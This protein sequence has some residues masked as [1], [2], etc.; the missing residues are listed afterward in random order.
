M[1]TGSSPTSNSMLAPDIIAAQSL[2]VEPE[3]FQA[4]LIKNLTKALLQDSPAPCLLR[5]PTGAGK[6]FVISRVLEAVSTKSPTIWLWFVP[7]VNLIQQTED[8]I[9]ANATALTPVPLV[10]G[11]NQEPASGLVALSTAAAVA[12]ATSRNAGYTDGVD[13]DVRSLEQ[14]VSLA[15]ARGFKIGLVVDEAH[16]GLATQTEFGK[17]ARWLRA[18][19]IVMASA[20]PKDQRLNDFLASAGLAG[21]VSFTASRDDVVN[22]RL[23]KRYIEAVV[24]DL[25][26]SMQTVTDL[27]QTVLRQAWRRNQR[28]LKQ[29]EA[30][31]M[32]FRPLLLVQVGNGATAVADARQSLMSLCNVNPAAIGEH[33]SDDPDPVLMASIANDQTKDVLIFKQSAGTGFDAPRAFVLA[34]TK[35][36]NDPDFALQFIGRVMRVHRQIRASYPR[37]SRVPVEL[38]TAYVYLANAQAQQGFEQ[39]VM[40]TAA[41]RSEL[42]GQTE[43]LVTR[44]TVAGGLHISNRATDEP[45]LWFDMPLPLPG[46]RP[47]PTAGATYTIGSSAGLFDGLDPQSD[48]ESTDDDPSEG[49]SLDVVQPP[50]ARTRRHRALPKD[51]GE[52]VE[53]LMD[54]GIRPYALRRSLREVPA[55]LM[56]EDRPVM[57][58]MAAASRSAAT[59]LEIAP[60]VLKTAVAV[61]LGRSLEQEVHTELTQGSV[62][63]TDVA[64]LVDRA[65]LAREARLVLAGLPQAE[66]ADAAIII[67][68]L[69]ARVLGAIEAEFAHLPE[70]ERP[71]TAEL[72]KRARD[73]AFWIIRKAAD[74][75][76]EMMH[77]EIAL[78]ARPVHSG[79]LP[80]YMVFPSSLALESSSKNLYGVLPPSRQTMD[81]LA[82]AVCIDTRSLMQTRSFSMDGEQ[83]LVS[84]YD[85]S[86]AL[87]DEERTF[88]RSLDRAPFV[89][90]WHRNPDRKPYSARL[91]RGEH[92]NY[93]YPDFIVCLEHFPGDEPLA[94]LVETK[95]STKDAARK[96]R[97]ASRLYG[98]VLFLTKDNRNLRL[99]NDDGSLGEV[100][101]L[102]DLQ[103]MREWLRKTVPTRSYDLGLAAANPKETQ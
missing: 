86:H 39:A 14:M 68:V 7:F 98:K 4:R 100:V 31:G 13:D 72:K 55:A 37:G 49:G 33:S 5:A 66:E 52:L 27:Q 6:T 102:D 2:A 3:D 23:N 95:E 29:I 60:S 90:W 74:D 53:Q 93:F 75:L 99:V 15:R 28:L 69:S 57:S 18:D 20:T 19:R 81:E 103:G 45:P 22:A 32:A 21:A 82:Q 34:S 88:A 97:H 59:R 30:A 48:P 71:S 38:D 35:P 50:P 94:R 36:V 83:V 10:R 62:T 16:I 101:D 96:S 92:Q 42:A 70:E 63:K 87:G 44:E 84:E 17:F 67:E 77:A 41:M 9:S 79:P 12:R 64:V 11:R 43:K 1:S 56:S 76:A 91:V 46:A 61:S 54:A 85:G 78:Q 89:E 24:Y 40:A 25:R 80:D 73:S 47:A 58:D 51:R 65:A 26:Q 8:S